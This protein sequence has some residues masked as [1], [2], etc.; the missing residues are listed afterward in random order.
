MATF[1]ENLKT[2][3]FKAFLPLVIPGVLGAWT[4]QMESSLA[5]WI[6]KLGAGAAI[7][8]IGW[9]LLTVAV[10]P[11]LWNMITHFLQESANKKR[12]KLLKK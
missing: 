7:P 4:L 2:W 1:I 5:A 8:W 11:A 9:G 10:A 3:G 12:R 6:T